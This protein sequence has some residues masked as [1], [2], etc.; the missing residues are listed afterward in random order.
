MPAALPEPRVETAPEPAPV[1]DVEAVAVQTE[2]MEGGV[3]GA[4]FSVG[5]DQPPVG[6]VPPAS[7]TTGPLDV[8]TPAKSNALTYA[9][10][11]GLALVVVAFF[12]RKGRK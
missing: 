5:T 10:I 4:N 12:L 7:R 11:A 3:D 8:Q 9:I 1:D 6:F 2:T